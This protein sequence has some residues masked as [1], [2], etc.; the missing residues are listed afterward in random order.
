[1]PDERWATF[2]V[3]GTLIDWMGGISA[4]LARIWPDEDADRLLERYHEL[5]T[6]Q[7]D[8]RAVSSRLVDALGRLYPDAVELLARTRAQAAGAFAPPRAA[9][10]RSASAP[11]PAAAGT[12]RAGTPRAP[13]CR[14]AP[15]SWPAVQIVTNGSP[16]PST[17]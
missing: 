6:G 15:S 10:H 9:Y 1:M 13:R 8:P 11:P 5:E 3:Y 12:P 2:D 16:W 4:G 17:S 14:A 7:L